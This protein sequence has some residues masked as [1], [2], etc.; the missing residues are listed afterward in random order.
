MKAVH[1]GAGN[2][3][4]GFLG[5]LYSRSGWETVFVDVDAT[6][7]AALNERRGYEIQIVGERSFAIEVGNVR[8]V[9]GRDADAVAREVAT[10]DLLGT[11]VGVGALPHVAP[12]L[13]RGIALRAQRQAPPISI[14]IC[15]NL[16]SAGAELRRMIEAHIPNEAADYLATQVGFV[17]TVISR[18]VPIVTADRR[19][20]DALYIAVEEYSVLPVDATAFVGPIPEIEGMDPRPNLEAYEER[21]IFTHNCAHALCSY[22]GYRKGYTFVW[23]TVR[24]PRL[25]SDVSKGLW[26]SGEALVLK[27]GFT[28]EQHQEHID[29]LLSRFANKALGDTIARC[30]RDSIRKLGRRDRL[31]GSALLALE[32][33]Q[34]PDMLVRG[35]VAALRYDNP[36][37]PKAVELQNR[38]TREGVDAVLEGVCGLSK[39][40]PLAEMIREGY[41]EGREPY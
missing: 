8:A 2:I 23:E 39:A 26:E 24:D 31:V 6:V 4:R 1:F 3:G 19:E 40:E 18:M 17:E 37:D 30:G 29:D 28:R 15:E 16:L 12:A 20:R 13:A 32:Y 35:I 7:I 41:E 10:A 11:S 21:K 33:G 22:F 27:H 36:E 34:R 38:L 25:R 5:Q 9:D 14:L